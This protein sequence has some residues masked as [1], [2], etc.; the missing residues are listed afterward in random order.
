MDINSWQAQL[1]KGSAELVVLSLLAGGERYGLEI[2]EQAGGVLSDGSIYPLLTRLEKE[3]KV[4]ARWAMPGDAKIPRKY[5]RLTREGAALVAEMQR[6][7]L[8]FS[9]F[10]SATLEEAN[11]GKRAARAGRAIPLRSL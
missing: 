8:E 2:L 4:K 10:V 11:D 5:Y 3:G 1:R 7:W 6:I 9:T